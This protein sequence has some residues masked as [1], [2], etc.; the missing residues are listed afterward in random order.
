[1]SHIARRDFLKAAPA[2]AAAV[3]S[4]AAAD[5]GAP[6]G[7]ATQAAT[8]P[9]PADTRISAIAYTPVTDYPIQPKRYCDVTLTDDFWK[10]KVAINAE[11]TIPFE[12]QKYAEMERQFGGNVLEAA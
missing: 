3:A 1:M 2:A 7:A 12:V 11:V 6:A 9:N 5:G 8:A 10:P 4:L